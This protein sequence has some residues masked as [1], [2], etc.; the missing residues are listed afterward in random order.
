MKIRKEL[1]FGFTLMGLILLNPR[2]MLLWIWC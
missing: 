1:Y 2:R